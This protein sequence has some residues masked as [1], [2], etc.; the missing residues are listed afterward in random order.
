MTIANPTL[1]R[2]A[3]TRRMRHCGNRLPV[4]LRAAMSIGLQKSLSADVEIPSI[5]AS[6]GWSLAI[7]EVRHPKPRG[8]V[9]SRSHTARTAPRPIY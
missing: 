6:Y 2:R 1:T 7:F 4:E 8:F 3:Q 5:R 9:V